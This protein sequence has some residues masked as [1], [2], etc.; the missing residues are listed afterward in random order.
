M[1]KKYITRLAEKQLELLMKTSGCVLVSGPKFCGKS[2]MCSKY[3]KSSVVLNT[4]DTILLAKANPQ[5]M[6]TGDKPH[7]ID[8]WQK[9]PD[10]WNY[11]KA[12]L[13][14]DYE[15]GKYI[16]TGS[17][18][19][20]NPSIIQHSGAGRITRMLLRPFSLYESGESKGQVS[21]KELFNDNYKFEAFINKTSDKTLLNIATF[22]CRG[23]WPISILSDID[24]SV[25]LTK[26]Y[27]NGLFTIENESDEFAYFLKDINIDL[28]KIILKS[29]ARNVSTQCKKRKMVSDILESGERI[30]LSEDTFD[31]YVKVLKDLF[32]IYDIHAWNTNLR[33][34]TIVR[35]APT[36]HF[37]DTSI[38]LAALDINPQDLLNDMKSF[39][40]FFEDFVTRDLL[41]YSQANNATLKHY[42]D[43]T[44]QEVDA[45]VELPNGE[46]GAIEIK[47]NSEDNINEGIKS[48]NSF[49][50]KLIKA[51]RNRPKFKMIITSHGNCYK[52]NDIFVVPITCLKD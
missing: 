45:I 40:L 33:S 47:I 30:K 51:R 12:D 23:G 34:S 31:K 8:E 39:G 52:K 29:Y 9:A 25:Q 1:R 19:P 36:H 38:A 6:L 28:L 16:I 3:A 14:E 26:N 15:F 17:T 18:T 20:A 5:I 41:I 49:E 48:L 21:L 7:L 50:N 37:V 43:S 24:D 13:D 10:I 35:T 27:Y 42:R 44:G 46:Y 4:N 2:E 11:I 32:I 22:M